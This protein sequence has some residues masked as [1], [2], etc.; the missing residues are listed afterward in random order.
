MIKTILSVVIMLDFTTSTA[1]ADEFLAIP[2]PR[3]KGNNYLVVIDLAKPDA[4]PKESIRCEAALPLYIL[5][6][7][8]A[9]TRVEQELVVRVKAKIITDAKGKTRASKVEVLMVC[10][11]PKS[12]LQ[13]LS[14]LRDWD[15]YS[16]PLP[17]ER[18]ASDAPV[19]GP[20]EAKPDP[21][22]PF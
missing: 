4:V 8:E 11:L 14:S 1:L 16:E 21:E 18:L 3:I 12:S 5:E 9:A 6:M 10:L 19:Q 17:N 22:D 7:A 2:R 15:K 20:V 13:H